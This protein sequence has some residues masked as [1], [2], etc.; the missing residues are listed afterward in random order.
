MN[1]EDTLDTRVGHRTTSF[2]E[3][4]TKQYIELHTINGVFNG[5]RKYLDIYK[6]LT[7][8]NKTELV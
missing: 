7:E 8:Y 5:D 3:R 4:E 1:N 6:T 2:L